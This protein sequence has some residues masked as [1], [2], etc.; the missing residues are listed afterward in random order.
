MGYSY[1]GLRAGGRSSTEASQMRYGC[2]PLITEQS[3]VD[4]QS[5]AQCGKSSPLLSFV[6]C[7]PSTVPIGLP[8][9]AALVA[10]M[11]CHRVMR[12]ASKHSV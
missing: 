2:G 9:M 11:F 4:Q 10:L 5:Y 6:L 3:L 1:L 7:L 12:S 8:L